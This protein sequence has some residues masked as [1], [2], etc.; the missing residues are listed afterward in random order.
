MMAGVPRLKLTLSRAADLHPP[1]MLRDERMA[2]LGKLP[3]GVRRANEGPD[4]AVFNVDR[5]GI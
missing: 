1:K 2:V 5:M 4:W 3:C